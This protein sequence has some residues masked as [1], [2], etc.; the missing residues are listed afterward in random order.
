MN[1]EI[2]WALVAPLLV[3]QAILMIIAL[4]DLT[5]TEKTNGPKWMWVLIVIFINTLGPILYFIIGKKHS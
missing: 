4:F 3:I 1:F 2:N 5:K